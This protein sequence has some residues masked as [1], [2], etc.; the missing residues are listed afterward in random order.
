MVLDLKPLS[1]TRL[2]LRQACDLGLAFGS[3]R[4]M[5]HSLAVCFGSGR[6]AILAL[7]A[8]HGDDTVTAQ[9]LKRSLSWEL[10]C[11]MQAEKM[12]DMLGPGSCISQ[13]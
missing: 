7:T 9:L 2:G 4:R 12:P 3:M 11:R 5:N 8:F 13:T 6:V 1:Q 10:S